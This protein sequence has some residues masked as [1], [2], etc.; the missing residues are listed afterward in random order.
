M[1]VLCVS[2]FPFAPQDDGG[3]TPMIWATEYKHIELVKL[4]LAKGSDVNIRDNV[5][6]FLESVSEIIHRF[7][8]KTE[9][10]QEGRFLG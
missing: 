4:L 1:S 5:R 3:W 6:F 10:A 7:S 8:L 2:P 9:Q